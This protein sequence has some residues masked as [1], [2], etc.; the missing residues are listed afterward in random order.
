MLYCLMRVI[1]T[2]TYKL[3]SVIHAEMRSSII[4]ML[5]LKYYIIYFFVGVQVQVYF[6]S[7]MKADHY[8][9]LFFKKKNNWKKCGCGSLPLEIMNSL[10]CKSWSPEHNLL[11]HENKLSPKKNWEL[12]QNKLKVILQKLSIILTL[13]TLFS[14]KKKNPQVIFTQKPTL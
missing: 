3:T 14:S 7:S 9:F 1:Y 6:G 12:Y 2:K 10:M 5:K 11:F 4:N 8:I 13:D